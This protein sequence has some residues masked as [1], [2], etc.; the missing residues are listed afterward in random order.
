MIVARN[1]GYHSN[2]EPISF[3]SI[4][5]LQGMCWDTTSGSETIT[6]NWVIQWEKAR[7][8]PQCIMT[9]CYIFVRP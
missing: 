1:C 5:R 7:L 9:G 6:V 2:L 3:K 8:V 4:G